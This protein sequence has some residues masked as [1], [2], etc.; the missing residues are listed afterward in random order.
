MSQTISRNIVTG[1]IYNSMF[2]DDR[3]SNRKEAVSQ[4]NMEFL[5]FEI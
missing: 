4:W 5:T 3:G 1:W 2:H